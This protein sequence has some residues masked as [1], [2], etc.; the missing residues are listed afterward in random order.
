M[1]VSKAPVVFIH[2]LWLHATSWGP[3]VDLFREAGYEPVAP[4]WPGDADTVEAARATRTASPATASAMSPAT[5]R[6]SS[7]S[8]RTA[9]HHR[10][11]VRRHDRREAARPGLRRGRHRHRHRLRLARGR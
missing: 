7:I 10:P 3:W 2:G 6:R 11:L 5:T 8:S 4:G 1:N 9:H